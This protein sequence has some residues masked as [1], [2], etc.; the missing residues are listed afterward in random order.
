[1]I[2]YDVAVIWRKKDIHYGVANKKKN[3]FKERV[4]LQLG[5]VGVL[6]AVTLHDESHGLG[7]QMMMVIVVIVMVMVVVMTM[8]V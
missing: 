1:V 5:V 2:S 8:V 7:V 3:L 4:E 6:P